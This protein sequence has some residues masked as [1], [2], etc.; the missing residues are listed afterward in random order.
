[1]V[2][3]RMG[4]IFR[5][6]R[7]ER[8]EAWRR[9]RSKGQQEEIRG[10]GQETGSIA[11]GTVRTMTKFGPA[12]SPAFFFSPGLGFLFL[13]EPDPATGRQKN[14]YRSCNVTTTG[15]EVHM[16]DTGSATRW[17]KAARKRLPRT[18]GSTWRAALDAA[19]EFR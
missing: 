3:W 14:A 5:D 1:M 10:S 4:V 6:S 2:M 9:R 18:R 13:P 7:R 19:V 8:R 11:I 16:T 12:P 15:S 17:S